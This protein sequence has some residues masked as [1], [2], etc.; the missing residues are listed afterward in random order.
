MRV[1][2]GGTTDGTV[3]PAPPSRGWATAAGWDASVV[4]NA[5]AP[6][7]EPGTDGGVRQDIDANSYLPGAP[8][9]PPF[10][11]AAPVRSSRRVAKRVVPVLIGGAMIAVVVSSG[12]GVSAALAAIGRMNRRWLVGAVGVELLMYLWLSL[13]VRI[14]AGPRINARRA[15]PVRIALVLFGLGNV[16]P[17]AP[18][19][20]LVLARAAMRRRRLDPRRITAMLG[21]AQWFNNR[22]LFTIAAVDV[23][24]A[25][26]V[27]DIPGPYR[28]G[29]VT[30]AVVTLALLAFTA[31]LSL[32]RA[33]A[34]SVA[35]VLLRFR[36]WRNCPS[37]ADRRA[38]G[39]AWHQVALHVSGGR[40]NRILLTATS[41]AAWVCDGLCMYLALRAAGARLELDRVLLAYT[42]GV[43]ASKVPLIPAGLGVVETLTPLVLTHYGVPW[44]RAI[45]V[46]LVYRLLSTLMPAV[47]G[48]LAVAGLQRQRQVRSGRPTPGRLSPQGHADAEASGPLDDRA[49]PAS[50]PQGAA[51]SVPPAGKS[52]A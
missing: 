13:V 51:A 3:T 4:R 19:E 30:A 8:M 20:G 41:A 12:S 15:A 26:A 38:R 7:P 42:A 10:G 27:G 5:S 37:P 52:V 22:A 29:A 47:A 14:L 44:T 23:L 48:V 33:T 21:C 40:H 31:W 50:A 18:A 39:V 25:A 45:A 24:V 36:Y 49:C 16:L 11:R 43:I 6:S 46:V 28:G 17:A 32:R 1:P 9:D 2:A 35:C 34:E